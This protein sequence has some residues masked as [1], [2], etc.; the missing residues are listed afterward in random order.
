LQERIRK[1]ENHRQHMSGRRKLARKTEN[2]RGR[3]KP[4]TIPEKNGWSHA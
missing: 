1:P 4:M 2:Q 3:G